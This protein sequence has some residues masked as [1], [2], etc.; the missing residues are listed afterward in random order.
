MAG[1]SNIFGGDSSDSKS[2]APQDAGADAEESNTID[3]AQAADPV[4]GDGD[5]PS[6]FE[7][8]KA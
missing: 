2:D 4:D 8:D 3:V 5:S 7:K 6:E 1:L